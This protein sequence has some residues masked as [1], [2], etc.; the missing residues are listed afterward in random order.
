MGVTFEDFQEPHFHVFL[1]L[2]TGANGLAN[3]RDF[4][5]PVAWYEDREVKFEIIG[6]YQGGLFSAEQVK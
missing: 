4:E 3:P 6:K 5:T 1:V 2:H